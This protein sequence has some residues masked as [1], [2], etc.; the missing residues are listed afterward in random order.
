MV[1]RHAAAT[2]ETPAVV[3]EMW[4]RW[5]TTCVLSGPR[6]SAFALSE[7]RLFRTGGKH[8]DGG[9]GRLAAT[10]RRTPLAVRRPTAAASGDHFTT[11]YPNNL[12]AID[13]TKPAA[14]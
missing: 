6:N 12:Y 5:I 1:G 14:P 4:L 10:F 3:A 11:P 9:T 2:G 8:P 13:L 7:Q